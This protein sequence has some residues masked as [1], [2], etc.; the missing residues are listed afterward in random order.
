MICGSRGKVVVSLGKMVAAMSKLGAVLG[1]AI[2]AVGIFFE[3]V[4]I[5]IGGDK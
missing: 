4:I 5:A 2:Q 1:R 3:T